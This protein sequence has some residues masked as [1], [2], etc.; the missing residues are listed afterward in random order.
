MLS[1]LLKYD[2]KSIFKPLIPIYGITIL[3]SILQRFFTW[4]GQ[5]WALLQIPAGFLTAFYII[6]LIALPIATFIFSILKYYN[7]LAKDEGYLMHTLPVSKGNLVLSKLLSAAISMLA[8]II[9]MFVAGVI[10]LVGII[11]LSDVLHFFQAV[12]EY[13][14]PLF[15]ILMI[16][17]AIGGYF[18][19]QLLFYLSMALGQKHNTHKVMYSIIYGIVL[20]NVMQIISTII[21]AFP[22]LFN[23]S[24]RDLIFHNQTPSIAFLNCYLGIAFVINAII[25]IIFYVAT[26]KI[27]EKNLNLD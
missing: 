12:L 16:I 23:S 25:I 7:N 27:L 19:Q 3:L 1:K 4:L 17:S 2:L 5:K 10:S 24:F 9:V 18:S 22:A 11:Q 13:T 15:I 26:T 20:Y 8:T 14:D 21:L 6:L